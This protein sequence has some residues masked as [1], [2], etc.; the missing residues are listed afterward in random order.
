[1]TEP[2]FTNWKNILEV[3]ELVEDTPETRSVVWGPG[4]YFPVHPIVTREPADD[5][6]GFQTDHNRCG[7][8]F[9]ISATLFLTARHVVE[10]PRHQTQWGYVIWFFNR[11]TGDWSHS[12]VQRLEMHDELDVAIGF[13]DE[14]R[15]NLTT[16]ALAAE[17]PPL[18]AEVLALGFP[19]GQYATDDSDGI[20]KLG[21]RFFLRHRRGVTE[22]ATDWH[23]RTYGK[24]C[25][26][27]AW[28]QPGASGGPLI[29]LSDG[30]ACGVTSLG[31]T[32]S[33]DLA[34]PTA[35][36]LDWRIDLLEGMTLRELAAKLGRPRLASEPP[37]GVPGME[38]SGVA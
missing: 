18:G 11:K 7:T 3:E 29:R 12:V 37:G 1:M 6:A 9:F 2:N 27:T 4:E 17:E 8:V 26:H 34:V 31:M 25:R 14:P 21:R 28:L 22:E 32:G 16:V 24:V 15:A 10:P 13:I 5:G 20:R 36:F 33:Y 30:A 35:A 38:D 19:G 23:R